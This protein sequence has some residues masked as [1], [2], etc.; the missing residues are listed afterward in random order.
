MSDKAPTEA[1][2]PEEPLPDAHPAGGLGGEN[3]RGEV[4]GCPT[5]LGDPEQAVVTQQP[6]GGGAPATGKAD[7]TAT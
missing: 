7:G 5:G 1:P 6:G 2:R 3:A 4:A